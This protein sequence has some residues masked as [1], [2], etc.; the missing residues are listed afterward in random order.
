VL[1]RS[2]LSNCPGGRR[3]AMC[4]PACHNPQTS[5]SMLLS[6][7]DLI[8]RRCTS[9]RASTPGRRC[10][11]DHSEDEACRRRGI[12]MLLLLLRPCGASRALGHLGQ[13]AANGTA[14]G[15]VNPRAS[16]AVA[17]QLPP[18]RQ[19]SCICFSLRSESRVLSVSDSVVQRLRFCSISGDF[20]P[21]SAAGPL[22]VP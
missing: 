3:Q 17:L 21:P 22:Q 15:S 11:R 14:L 2:T 8:S 18:V 6:I 5:E 7:R 19:D 20:R 16:L 12:S 10:D 1:G 4:Q 9:L 13:V